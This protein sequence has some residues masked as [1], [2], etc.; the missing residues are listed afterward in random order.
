VKSTSSTPQTKNTGRNH[1]YYDDDDDDDDDDFVAE[2]RYNIF[3]PV[4]NI[5]MER[6]KATGSDHRNNNVSW[7]RSFFACFDLDEI[8]LAICKTDL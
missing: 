7:S 3:S 8:R 4:H 1:D 5:I 2:P 6:D